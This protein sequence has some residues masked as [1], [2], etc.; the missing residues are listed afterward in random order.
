MRPSPS[1]PHSQL[2]QMIQ[3]FNPE[4]Q[5]LILQPPS[6]RNRNP[7]RVRPPFGQGTDSIACPYRLP[8]SRPLS[9]RTIEAA[10]CSKSS[11]HTAPGFESGRPVVS[12]TTSI[13]VFNPTVRVPSSFSNQQPLQMPIMVSGPMGQ[14]RHE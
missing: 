10:G 4:F 6:I 14:Q 7:G 13:C 3:R 1:P 11:Y 2:P 9:T 12:H 5:V 8:R